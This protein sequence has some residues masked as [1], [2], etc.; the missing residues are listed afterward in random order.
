MS[1]DVIHIGSALLKL[2]PET[3]VGQTTSPSGASRRGSH[4]LADMGTCPR[5]WFLRYHA[6]FMSKV[7]RAVIISGSLIHGALAW[8]YSQRMDPRDRPSWGGLTLPEVLAP[9][10]LGH[11]ELIRNSVACLAAYK[12]YWDKMPN[13]DPWR[14]KYIE[15]EFE[16]RI[17]DL[18]KAGRGC[19]YGGLCVDDEV[20][21][22]K[23]DL[24]VD[25]DG[26]GNLWLVDHKTQ[27]PEWGKKTLSPYKDA[28]PFTVSWQSLLYLHIIRLY[29]PH[30]A[31]MIIQRIN[32]EPPYDVIRM[33]IPT[34]DLYKDV[35]AIAREMVRRE[36]QLG[37]DLAKGIK[38]T[39]HPWA[40]ESR[41]G[42]CDYR[43]LCV[44]S[45][46]DKLDIL[47]HDYLRLQDA[48]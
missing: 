27:R 20:V 35:P 22:C 10:G 40:C 28:G 34:A 41:F 38:A 11:P 46:A 16:A 6:R 18:D 44:A 24:I 33:P 30:V 43:P 26:T 15:Q 47:E 14:P 36:M 21:T 12:A 5:K 17:S 48:A 39:A 25:V 45:G 42:S 1:D 9:I 8:D 7:E 3:Q 13:G 29:M 23:P 32:R 37:I 19:D 31:G 4:R 2:P